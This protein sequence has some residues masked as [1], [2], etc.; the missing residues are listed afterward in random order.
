MPVSVPETRGPVLNKWLAH[1]S[2]LLCFS[3]II[4]QITILKSHEYKDN[5]G[6]V[7]IIVLIVTGRISRPS[8]PG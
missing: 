6:N 7:L 5:V 3:E 2:D 4:S 8:S 1:G